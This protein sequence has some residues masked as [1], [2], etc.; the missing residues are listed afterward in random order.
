MLLCPGRVWGAAK[1]RRGLG[2]VISSDMSLKR[3]NMAF[4]CHDAHTLVEYAVGDRKHGAQEYRGLG[5]AVSRC[6][7]SG[8][9]KLRAPD[10]NYASVT[11]RWGKH[12][13]DYSTVQ[14][15][16]EVILIISAACT[17]PQTLQRTVFA[18]GARRLFL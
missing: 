11:V 1:A 13:G 18:R 9:R 16:C 10:A 17:L 15:P 2:R 6:G 8:R 3:R 14:G 12:L 7:R 5:G 4:C